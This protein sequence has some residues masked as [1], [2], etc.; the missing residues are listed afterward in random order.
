[1]RRRDRGVP[2]DD[3]PR[4]CTAALLVSSRGVPLD[5]VPRGTP[6]GVQV[7]V[8]SREFGAAR[9]SVTRSRDRD[10]GGDRDHDRLVAGPQ[11]QR[12][13]ELDRSASYKCQVS[14]P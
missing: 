5:G 7:C 12:E 11:L 8:R 2:P 4:V 14:K 1:M 3:A 13:Q 9:C 10:R 6:R